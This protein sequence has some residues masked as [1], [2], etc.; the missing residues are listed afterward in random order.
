MRL[1]ILFLLFAKSLCDDLYFYDSESKNDYNW[2]I[3]KKTED[4][5]IQTD[6]DVIKF[7][8]GKEI[9]DKCQGQ[10]A[11]AIRY[12]KTKDYCEILGRHQLMYAIPLK[13]FNTTG[14]AVFY[15]GGSICQHKRWANLK[16]RV[17]FKL[18]CSE[19]DSDFV[20]KSSLNDCTTIFE[21]T[22]PAGCIKKVHKYNIFIKAILLL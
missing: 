8:L 7:N 19:F 10:S 1:E 11:S 17:E 3:L 13:K 14:I 12:S 15:D 9:K 21:K 5:L 22:T 20:I 4:Y 6:T 2:E 18:I 16:K